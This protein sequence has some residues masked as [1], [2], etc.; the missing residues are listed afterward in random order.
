MIKMVGLKNVL[1]V[2]ENK[3]FFD[4]IK[5]ILPPDEF[6]LTL[7]VSG[8]EAR[9]FIVTRHFDIL[10]INSP[11]PDEH[12]L[13]FARDYVDTSMGIL[14]VC[15]ADAYDGIAAEAEDQGIVVLSNA[16]P[17]A[18]IYVAV[19][20]IAS[21]IKR[22]E[23]L[24]KKNRTLQD[25]MGDI[26]IINKAKWMLIDKKKMSEPDAHKYIEKRAMDDRISSKQAA[27]DIIDELSI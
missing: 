21:M 11:L 23:R 19:K 15:P 13:S 3:A 27:E 14:M 26:R 9:R 12:G 22:L 2:S 1:V 16:N 25:K 10:V 17:P 4:S 18:F 24:E 6:D 8:S 7:S 5:I 20:M